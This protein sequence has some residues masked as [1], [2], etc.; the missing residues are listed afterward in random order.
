LAQLG[1]DC[2]A[3]GDKPLTI[4]EA[5]AFINEQVLRV[6]T[7]RETLPLAACDG[8]IID[9]MLLARSALPPFSNSAVDGYAVRHADLALHGETRLRVLGR[10]QAGA[11]AI[12]AL[13]ER[14][15]MRI[16][17]GAPLPEG[18]DTVFMQED[19]RLDDGVA[20]LPA[21]LKRGANA[22]ERMEELDIGEPLFAAGQRLLP[23]HLA[24]AAGA[25]FAELPVRKRLRAALFSTGDELVEP[26]AP[27]R[28]SRV[29]DSNRVMLR[30]LLERAGCAVTDLGILCDD[31]ESVR[32]ALMGAA[33]SHDLIVTSGGVSTG[34]ADH[35]KSAV[36]A[37]GRL[38]HWRFAIKPGRPL[39]IG[40]VGGCAFVGLPGN[41]VA[42]FVTFTQVVRAVIAALAGESW[43]PPPF[44]PVRSGFGRAKKAGRIEFIR[45][46]L[47]AGPQGLC[48]EPYPIEGAG[49]ISS[50]AFTDGLVRLPMGCAGVSIGDMVDY[51]PFAAMMG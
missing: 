28:G 39:A 12:P 45:V 11:A 37:D 31:L 47:N 3:F 34:E 23:Q 30:A 8:R 6:A 51:A 25:G 36:Q 46:S 27:L 22:R 9:E 21:G 18:S 20:V 4:D 16:F 2:F 49:I 44:L 13:A 43:R 32:R 33:A 29:Y 26:G 41:P 24:L 17:T 38:D 5:L 1:D 7:G 14:S 15:A 10:L 35:V 42:A 40:V 50:L 19:V 48:A